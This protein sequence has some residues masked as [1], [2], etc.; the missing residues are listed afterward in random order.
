MCGFS[1]AISSAR[2]HLVEK[3]ADHLVVKTPPELPEHVDSDIAIELLW[4]ALAWRNAC[5]A[6]GVS[7]EL[8]QAERTVDLHFLSGV[9]AELSRSKDHTTAYWACKVVLDIIDHIVWE[10]VN[11]VW[12]TE[13]LDDGDVEDLEDVDV[14]AAEVTEEEGEAAD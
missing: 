6:D 1:E 12:E 14:E 9:A 13:D 11:G 7:A 4:Y 5:V 10:K 3:C 2:R 8:A